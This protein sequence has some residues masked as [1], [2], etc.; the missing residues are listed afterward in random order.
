MLSLLAATIKVAE[1]ILIVACVAIVVGVIVGIIVRRL[2]GKSACCDEC[3]G[4][5]A[6]CQSHNKTDRVE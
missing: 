3:S 2:K 4:D 5:C 1:I 6:C